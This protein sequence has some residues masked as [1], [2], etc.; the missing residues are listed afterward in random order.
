MLYQLEEIA[1]GGTEVN[2]NWFYPD[3]DDDL[4]DAGE[5]FERLVDLPFQHIPYEKEYE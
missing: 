4:L 2:V 1:D 5:E 3:D